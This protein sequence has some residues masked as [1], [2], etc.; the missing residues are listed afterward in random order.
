MLIETSAQSVFY[1]YLLGAGMMALGGAVAWRY[2]VDAERRP[3]E[4]IASPLATR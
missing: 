3:L 1:G 4:E 2:G